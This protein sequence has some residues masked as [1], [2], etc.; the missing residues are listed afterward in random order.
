MMRRVPLAFVF[1]AVCAFGQAAP[2]PAPVEVVNFDSMEVK[3]AQVLKGA[4]R[5]QLNW[6]MGFI[7]QSLGVRCDYC[8]V[9]NA[10]GMQYE[11]D[12]KKEKQKARD[13]LRMAK[14][15]ND[16]NFDGRQRV[17][18]A[19]CHNGRT[20]PR[21]FTPIVDADLLK[22]RAAQA[23][24]APGQGASASAPNPSAAELLTKYETAIGGE[25]ALAKLSTRSDKWTIMGL[26]PNPASGETVRK[27]PD[28]WI[29]TTTSAPNRSTTWVSNGTEARIVTP[30][31]YEDVTGAD[32][33]DVKFMSSFWQT[34]KPS[35]I[36]SR[37]T[38]TGQQEVNGHRAYVVDAEL[39]GLKPKEKLFFDADS[40]LLLRRIIFRATLLGALADQTDF[41]DYRVVDGVKVPFLVK[42]A[43]GLS[44]NTRTY[45]DIRFNVSVDDTKFAMPAPPQANK[46]N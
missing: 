16:Q 29:E 24:R 21:A 5:D 15:I 2:K 1:L 4:T 7:S 43:N 27:A 6:A 10:K 12:D 35:E 17:T 28:K 20:Q 23:P 31:F 37:A 40:G 44:T 9:M 32:L 39:K 25:A 30:F 41:D 38:T 34:L 42:S 19:T 22:E 18:C 26:G 3:N 11:L 8:H 33:D 46:R 13:M 14:L 36:V 45:T